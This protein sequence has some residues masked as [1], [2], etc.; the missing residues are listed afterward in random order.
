[1]HTQIHKHTTYAGG[2]GDGLGDC[3]LSKGGQDHGAREPVCD[4]CQDAVTE[5]GGHGVC[6]CVRACVCVCACVC[7]C[8]CACVC[9]RVCVRVHVCVCVCLRVRVCACVRACVCVCACA[10]VCVCLRVCAC[11]CVLT[12][13]HCAQTMVLSF[14]LHGS[15]HG[16][17]E[18]SPLTLSSVAAAH[19]APWQWMTFT[20]T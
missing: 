16:G 6:V 10:C 3:Q 12:C 18:G 8:V 11:A 9:V 13:V 4:R 7:M 1:M 5:L 2:S 19:Y 17:E 20:H 15:S 14:S